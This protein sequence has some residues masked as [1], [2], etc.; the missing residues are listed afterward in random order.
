MAHLGV[1][2]KSVFS[3]DVVEICCLPGEIIKVSIMF[4]YADVQILS[5]CFPFILLCPCS[6]ILFINNLFLSRSTLGDGS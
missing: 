3:I 6:L 2:L 1:L 5:M 4:E